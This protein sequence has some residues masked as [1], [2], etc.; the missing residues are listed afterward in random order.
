M[1]RPEEARAAIAEARRL[2]PE[3][4]LTELEGFFGEELVDGLRA[5]G[6]E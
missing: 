5:T 4:S 6:V 1:G 3:L 2:R